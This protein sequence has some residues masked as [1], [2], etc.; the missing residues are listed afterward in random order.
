MVLKNLTFELVRLKVIFSGE[1][2]VLI[3]LL[4]RGPRLWIVMVSISGSAGSGPL[5]STANKHTFQKTQHF[6]FCDLK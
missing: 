6:F 3:L 2:K 1:G 5:G 4:K